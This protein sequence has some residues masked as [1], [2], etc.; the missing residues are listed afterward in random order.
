MLKL[1]DRNHNAIGHITKY[2]DCKIESD[3]ST[4]DKTLSFTYLAKRHHLENEMYVQTRDDEYVIKEAPADSSGFPQ[5]VA[6]LNLEGLQAKAW[7][8]FSVTD[9]TIDEAARTALA[10][11]GWTVGYCDVTKRR[12]AGMM[13]VNTLGVIQNLCKAFMCEPVY[14]T[15]N[16]TVSFYQKRGED[17]GVYFLAG[18]NLKR[19]QKKSGSHEF[20]TR[21]IPIG[22]NG[23]TIES[24]NDGKNYLENYQ[25]SNKV[26]TYIW[27]DE[28]Y[29]DAQALKEDAELWLADHAKPEVSYQAY[30][31]NLAAQKPGYSVLSYGPGD[32]VKL[33]DKTTGTLE[34]QR[35]VKMV[36]YPDNPDKDTCEIA[37]TVLTFEEMQEKVQEAAAII[38][39]TVSGDGRYTGTI[40]VS[41]ILHFED[42]LAGSGTIGGI[43][44]SITD[45]QGKLALTDL[46]VGEIKTNYLK[47]DEA[48]LKYATVADLNVTNETV[49]SI[50]GDYASFKSL[51]TDEF[52]SHTALID[53]IYNEELVTAKGW[54]LEGS[55]GDAQI[56]SLNANKLRAGTIDTA[57][58]TVAG[59]DGR[60][61]ISDNTIQISDGTHVRVQAGKDASG[62]YTL[63]VW[64]AG[65]NLIWDA[66]GATEN[67]IQRKIIRDKMVAD[68]AAI[69]ALKIDFQSFDTALTQQGVAIS[70]TVVQAGSKTLNV[71][72]SEQTQAISEHGDMLTDHA[73]KIEANERAISLRVTSQEFESYKSD[74]DS[75]IAGAKSRLSA[76]ESSITAMQGQIALKVGQTDIDKSLEGYST[77]AQMNAAISLSGAG[78]L[79][80][81]SRTYATQDRVEEIGTTAEQAADRIG[82]L[83]KSGTSAT[84][85]TL[86]DRTAQLITEN[87][88]I[89]DKTGAATIISGGRMDI[90]QIFAQDITA[91]G[92]IR[93]V[94]L[95]GATGS[96]SGSVTATSGY[97]GDLTITD[98]YLAG[99]NGSGHIIVGT[100]FINIYTGSPN[101]STR[102]YASADGAVSAS[103]VYAS[104]AVTTDGSITAAGNIKAASMTSTG[105]LTAASAAVSGTLTAAGIALGN[106]GMQLPDHGG[107]FIGGMSKGPIVAA[108]HTGTRYYP[109]IRQDTS[110][111]NVFNL[112]G[113]SAS[114]TEE[115]F[116]IY[117]WK[118]GRTENGVD[119]WVWLN[120]VDGTLN[121]NGYIFKTSGGIQA[122]GDISGKSLNADTEIYTPGTITAGG[123]ISTVGT[124]STTGALK[125][126]GTVHMTNVYDYTTT[127]TANVR[128]GSTGRLARYSSSS[129]R[130]K[131][132]ISVLSAED[133]EALYDI[134]VHWFKYKEGYI[135]AEDERYRKNIPGFAVEDWEDILPIAIDHNPDG[136]PEMW[137]SNIVVPLM[138]EM[139][140]NE[141]R[142]NTEVRSSLQEMQEYGGRIAAA[143]S[144]IT[145]AEDRM[146]VLQEQLNAARDEIR[147]LR[148]EIAEQAAIIAGM[149]AA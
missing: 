113:I 48:D 23:L 28:S 101:S 122:N 9:T 82:W 61:Q 7:Q 96:F 3:V 136:S 52:A 32:T 69:Q 42:G 67:T 72:L 88:T 35:I 25:Y 74:T 132:L 18:L 149:Q 130:Y 94:N 19:L 103:S 37:N 144:R 123:T 124:I 63:A 98:G 104:N 36:H 93:G 21:V 138:F 11:S 87:L 106:G 15:K 54:M 128:V 91:T 137:N 148:A 120:A 142:R 105:S 112:G 51:T 16:K 44:N 20:Y 118:S 13:H 62:D 141:H 127:S 126:D 111:G 31:R 38:N 58:I 26:L 146:G 77:T 8:T 85:F 68:D 108:A 81:V 117:A 145:S 22:E 109:V 57:I 60:L 115:R 65:G 49:H 95:V 119:Y 107:M 64:D 27:K 80:T 147:T 70:G 86:T 45:I 73:A 30:V 29:T 100:D 47:A 4:G 131:D 139:I 99:A 121:H 89:K 78:I 1:F 5:I 79:N 84:N 114:S 133:V 90:D 129:V 66:L 56:S 24:V 43:N 75:E 10:G 2:R 14:D 12:N 135:G 55:I 53:K 134:P 6:V 83:V 76:T 17:K 50:Q 125:V 33:A 143:E 40:S 59:T 39:F 46:T 116:G 34:E 71:A 41:D 102:F 97:I 110:S 140:K 92:T